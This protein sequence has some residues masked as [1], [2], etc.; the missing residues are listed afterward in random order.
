[1]GTPLATGIFNLAVPS[2]SSQENQGLAVEARKVDERAQTFARGKI[3]RDHIVL[4][5]TIEPAVR[6]ESKPPRFFE[7]CQRIWSQDANK[8]AI[9][10]IILADRGERVR[11]AKRM[12]TAHDHISI[13]RDGEIERAERCIGHLPRRNY[14]FFRIECQNCVVAF[15][16]RTDTGC[17]KE[18]AVVC[19]CKTTRK[20][21]H[22][23][24]KCGFADARKGRFESH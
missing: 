17:Q 23:W 22:G 15:A 24:W 13:W 1:M 20:R 21:D 16:A 4:R 6:P 9:A 3:E 18:G 14:S 8:M 12:L 7:S 10:S 11:N 2:F 19:E 5:H